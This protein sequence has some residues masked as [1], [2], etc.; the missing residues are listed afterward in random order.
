MTQKQESDAPMVPVPYIAPYAYA[1]GTVGTKFYTELRDNKRILGIR[2][3][4]CNM[5]FIPPRSS[6]PRCLGKLDEFVELGNQG[7][8]LTYT[9][10][11]YREPI[12]PVEAPFAYGIIQLDGADT[13]ITHLLGEVEPENIS[14]GMRVEAVFRE[15]RQGNLLDIRYFRPL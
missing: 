12:H 10:V 14:I 1:V 7:T 15:E 11:R 2:C 13:A 8:L 5:I 3:H 9:V 6:C 4:Q